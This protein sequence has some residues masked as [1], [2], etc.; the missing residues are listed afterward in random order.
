MKVAA[1][2]VALCASASIASPALADDAQPDTYPTA[3]A[4]RPLT[5]PRMMLSPELSLGLTHFEI[6][7]ALGSAAANAVGLNLGAGLGITNDL[8]VYLVPLTMLIA[9]YTTAA[10]TKVYYGTFRA[11]AMYRFVHTDKVDFGGQFEFAASG[12]AEAVY[13]TFKL[14][15]LLRIAPVL[16][17]DT[18]LAFTVAYPTSGAS[19]DA[20]FA[21][22]SN[23]GAAIVGLG[24]SAGIPVAVTIQP[25]EHVFFG[26]DTGFGVGSFRGTVSNSTFM[27]LGAF[28]GGTIPGSKG[29]L[30]DIVGNFG[31]PFFLLGA[32][33]SPP[34]TQLWQVGL[35]VRAYLPLQ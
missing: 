5:L 30:V 33:A 12:A 11:G 2:A 31:F 1:A 3:Y 26:L 4:E 27:P 34:T 28:V 19:V 9:T 18:G 25:E 21:T 20:G 22:V 23:G 13:T 10:P 16:R 24:S 32:D 15:L 14:P 35:G 29:P 7:T 6:T 8:T 17:I